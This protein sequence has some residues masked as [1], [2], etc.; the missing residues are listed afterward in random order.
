[1]NHLRLKDR[2]IT[3][4]V[5]SL[6]LLSPKP[7]PLTIRRWWVCLAYALKTK[8]GLKGLLRILMT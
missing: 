7:L 3:C 1:M 8:D 2:V 4:I 5:S 6:S